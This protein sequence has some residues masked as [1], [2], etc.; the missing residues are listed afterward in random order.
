MRSMYGV[1]RISFSI[2]S[3]PV[4]LMPF[5]FSHSAKTVAVCK[6]FTP[7]HNLCAFFSAFMVVF[8]RSTLSGCSYFCFEQPA[9]FPR[10]VPPLAR[11]PSKSVPTIRFTVFAL[12][13]EVKFV[14]GGSEGL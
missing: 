7:D 11:I 12:S 2:L 8:V 4:H 10:A 5:I 9:G 6:C 3:Q 1:S 13:L 14:E